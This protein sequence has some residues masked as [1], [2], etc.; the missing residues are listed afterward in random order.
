MLKYYIFE[1]GGTFGKKE[2]VIEAPQYYIPIVVILNNYVVTTS[3][4]A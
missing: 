1:M 4:E 2:R 3:R